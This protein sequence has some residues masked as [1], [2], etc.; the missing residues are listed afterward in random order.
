MNSF[1]N[2]TPSGRSASSKI[3][4]IEEQNEIVK[5]WTPKVRQKLRASTRRFVNGKTQSMVQRPG[6]SEEK[7]RKSI[8]SR[9]GKDGQEIELISFNFERHGV[10]V[11]KGVSRNHPISN[12]RDK[13]DWFNS[14]LDK[15]IPELA[16]NVADV[17]A[18]ASV[19]ATRMK[20][21]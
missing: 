16:D 2:N 21:Q 18:E 11:H 10:F 20:I 13:S 6:R 15:L 8:R 9:F 14:T 19:N 3:R 7:L 4:I 12:P 17:N 1:V 5:K